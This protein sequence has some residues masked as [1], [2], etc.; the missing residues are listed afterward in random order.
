MAPLP[1]A[2]MV[3]PGLA[4]RFADA[5][6]PRLG[7]PGS[8]VLE[9]HASPSTATGPPTSRVGVREGP[10]GRSPRISRLRWRALN[11][12]S[13]ALRVPWSKSPAGLRQHP[14]SQLH[15][16]TSIENRGHRGRDRL[17]SPRSRRLTGRFNVEF[18]S[19]IDGP[20][21]AGHGRWAAVRRLP[22][23]RVLERVATAP[24]R[25]F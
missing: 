5:C 19:P 20:L 3:P 14:P 22:L 16:S 21:H 7:R 17:R 9:R 6:A 12:R 25:E 13:A 2:R 10:A 24:T 8:V 23:A 15:G 1:S 11:A 18:V 4:T